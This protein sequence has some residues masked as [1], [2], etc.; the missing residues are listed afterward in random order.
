MHSLYAILGLEENSSL[1]AVETRYQNLL[2]ALD[3]NRF[4]PDSL[5]YNQA[6]KCLQAMESAYKTLMDPQLKAAY[7]KEWK[8]AIEADSQGEVQPKLGQL[9]VAAGMITM[10][11]LE[12]AV[13]T[14]TTL[15]LPI[16][17]IL[18]EHKLIS[19]AELDGLLMGQH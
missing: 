17:Q 18:Q 5:G 9:C 6:Q 11:D 14:Q 4:S 2:V 10:E 19:Q 12:T 13:R 7:E 8:A 16:G 1:S 3:L 15:N